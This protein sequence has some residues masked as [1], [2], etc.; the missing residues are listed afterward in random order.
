ML[1]TFHSRIRLSIG[2]LGGAVLVAS[3][4]SWAY[5]LHA[6]ADRYTWVMADRSNDAAGGSAEL[7]QVSARCVR[8]YFVKALLRSKAELQ[9]H[10]QRAPEEIRA[11]LDPRASQSVEPAAWHPRETATPNDIGRSGRDNEYI[12][13][14][15][16]KYAEW[17][18]TLFKL[19]IKANDWQQ[20]LLNLADQTVVLSAASR[21]SFGEYAHGNMKLISSPGDFDGYLLTTLGLGGLPGDE[22]MALKSNCVT[23]SLV[24]Q[25][26]GG[27][28]YLAE[29]WRWP[30][31]CLAEFLLGLELVLISIFFAPM[32]R[33]I[34]TGDLEAVGRPLR[35]LANRLDA[36]IRS[37]DRDRFI[38]AALERFRQ[39][40]TIAAAGYRFSSADLTRRWQRSWQRR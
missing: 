33:W 16:V 4:L 7:W 35:N 11:Q 29:L 9:G 27:P 38:R 37:F 18:A 36:G 23:V 13:E 1:L 39:M 25:S 12:A 17:Y 31:D 21:K 6:A 19:E 15:Q 22:E 28:N 14:L 5:S 8:P 2:L 34:E 24:K 3:L 30:I 40:R 20:R 26:V 10:Y 32:A